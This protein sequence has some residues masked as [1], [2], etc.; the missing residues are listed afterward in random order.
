MEIKDSVVL[1]TGANRGIGA[2][3]VDAFVAA[4]A[5]R[6]YAGMRTPA[7][8]AAGSKVVPVA[9]DV[10]NQEQVAAVARAHG[11]VQ[12][13]VNN[14]GVL[15][16]PPL[17][18]APDLQ[19]AEQEMKVNYFGTLHMARAFA[20]VLARNGGGA[21]VN[22]LSIL[23]RVASPAVGSYSASKAAAASATQA[24]RA[25]LERQGTLVIGVFPGLVDTD[26]ARNMTRPKI[27]PA[28]VADAVIDGV[29][30]NIEDVYPGPAAETEAALRRD[31]KA[32][33]RLFAARLNAP[34]EGAR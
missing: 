31:P 25:E 26:M 2:A 29:R 28:A 1:I 6:V 24:L 8:A 3:L 30:R 12:I 21:L 11:D 18:Q 19:A 16:S 5:R 33:E 7:P 15:A 32:V 20:P 9:L 34:T 27:T 13:V 22:V 23:G 10:T 14:A 17:L 4:G